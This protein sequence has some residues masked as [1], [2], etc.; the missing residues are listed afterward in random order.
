MTPLNNY[1]RQALRRR[2]NS[3][4][5]GEE[6]PANDLAK[7]AILLQE[8]LEGQA[9]RIQALERHVKALEKLLKR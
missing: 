1:Q 9:V 5:S 2:I 8:A 3:M 4:T 6:S 7:A